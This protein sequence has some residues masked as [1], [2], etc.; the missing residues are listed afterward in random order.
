M[1]LTTQM[2]TLSLRR[3]ESLIQSFSHL[4]WVVKILLQHDLD[5]TFILFYYDQWWQKCIEKLMSKTKTDK[6]TGIIVAGFQKKVKKVMNKGW[7]NVSSSVNSKIFILFIFYSKPK[8]W[9]WRSQ[10]LL[11]CH[12]VI[13][14]L[15][16]ADC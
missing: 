9:K 16:E 13:L 7:F 12:F 4:P 5:W 15:L 11:F 2:R 3:K 10:E 8:F 6:N 14:N 1:T